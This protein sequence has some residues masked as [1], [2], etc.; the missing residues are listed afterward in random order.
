[1]L[2]NNK[3][4]IKTINKLNLTEDERE[5]FNKISED[6]KGN[7]IY[8]GKSIINGATAEQAAQIQA[9]KT[10]IGDDNGGL[11]K[12]VN[13]L[14]LESHNH[15]NI[16]ILES[17]DKQSIYLT[18]AQY[19]ALSTEEKNDTT[20]VYN[21]TDATITETNNYILSIDGYNL[22][23]QKD[24]GEIVSTV[25]LE[26][27]KNSSSV[28]YGALIVEPTTLKLSASSSGNFSIKL[29]SAPTNEQEVIISTRDTDIT[30]SKNTIK[31]DSSNYDTPQVIEVTTGTNYIG[32]TISLSTTNSTVNVTLTKVSESGGSSSGGSSS[33]GS[34]SGGSSSGIATLL[35]SSDIVNKSYL[36]TSGQIVST[37]SN[38][39]VINKFIP[40]DQDSTYIFTSIDGRTN[41]T[42]TICSYAADKDFIQRN[43]AQSVT[44]L[45]FNPSS[46][47]C[48]VKCSTSDST[49]DN[50]IFYSTKECNNYLINKPTFTTGVINSTDGSI[51]TGDKTSNTIN[52][53][54]PVDNSK[55]LNVSV[56]NNTNFGSLF[57]AEY[58]TDKNFIIRNKFENSNTASLSLNASTSYIRIGASKSVLYL[59]QLSN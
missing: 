27:L 11:I 34:S 45:T 7:F 42:Y 59:I 44:F 26:F 48:Y 47:E 10:A 38:E 46:T 21:I 33:G 50:T 35:N 6:D 49:L 9:N 8:N 51:N 58:D 24:T 1:M 30:L 39:I 12:K 56:Y 19:D 18:Q 52:E 40:V 54:I 23:L 43:K 28:T 32:G 31:F 36:D 3:S 16:S 41:Y 17:I 4:L 53:Y 22:R 13:S 57:I 15:S 37:N 2:I 20:K 29:S 14:S 25:S 55:S 5:K